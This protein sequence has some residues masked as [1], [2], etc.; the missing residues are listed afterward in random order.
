MLCLS[1]IIKI[2]FVE[3]PKYYT[4]YLKALQLRHS[5]SVYNAFYLI[6]LQ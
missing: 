2:R 4:K 5:L 6:I 3:D 1:F